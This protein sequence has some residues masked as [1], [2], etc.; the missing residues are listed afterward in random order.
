MLAAER[1]R[2][3]DP[4]DGLRYYTGGWNISNR[5]YLAV[6]SWVLLLPVAGRLPLMPVQS[7]LFLCSDVHVVRRPVCCC[8]Q[9][10][11][12]SAAPVF[13]LAALWFVAVAAAALLACCCRC[14]RGGG[15]NYSYSRRVFAISL[16]L[17]IV[18]TAAAV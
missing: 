3:Q 14:C 6:S 18:F 9:S 16:V 13:V 1:T 7:I 5:H 15:S 4:L 17:L 10:A 11:G 12:F 8:V 2:R